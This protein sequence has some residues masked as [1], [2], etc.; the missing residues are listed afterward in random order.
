[1]SASYRNFKLGVYCKTSRLSGRFDEIAREIVFFRA[2]LK[3][4][5][6]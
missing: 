4:S 2:Y 5:K 6:T 1:L 3:L